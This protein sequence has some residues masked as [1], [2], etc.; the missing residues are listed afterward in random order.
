MAPRLIRRRPLA[1]RIKIYLN[2][3]DFLLWLS[4]ELDSNEWA[5]WKLKWAIPIGVALNVLFLIARANSVQSTR[6]KGDGVFADDEGYA[7]WLAW[8]VGAHTYLDISSLV[9]IVQGVLCRSCSY[10][11]FVC[12]CV[13]HILAQTS[14]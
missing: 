7:G 12:K 14:L 13:L 11:I 3:L 2:P 4:E 10:L 6:G 5:Q 8:V 9:L 1:E